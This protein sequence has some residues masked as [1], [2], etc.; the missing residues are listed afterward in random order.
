[1]NDF[2]LELTVEE[3]P[4]R[5]Q[6]T[7]IADF[8]RLMIAELE[9]LRIA[10]EDIRS[11]ISPKRIVFS[12]KLSEK[13]E[14]FVEEKKGPQIVAPT[15]VIEK[16]LKANNASKDDCV[17]REVDKKTFLFIEINHEARDVRDLLGEAIKNAVAKIPWKKSMRWGSGHFY[18][19]RPL[20]NIMAVFDGKPLEGEFEEI[21]LKFC[22]HTFGHRFL[23]P[24]KIEAKNV[25][26]YLENMRKAFVI[27]DANERRKM[28][29]NEFKKLESERNLSIEADEKLLDEVV[30]LIEH[31][32]V[33]LGKVPQKF[34]EL[35]EEA[36]IT[37]M[38]VHQR[39]F[40]TKSNGKL[41]PFFVF[42]ADNIA[43][44]GGKTIIAGNERVLNARLADALFFFETDL[45]KPLESRLEDLKKIAF[46][47]KL[48]TIFDRVQRVANVCDYLGDSLKFGNKESLRRAAILAKCDL[49][50]GMVGEFAE[51]QG[52]MGSHYARTQ[53]EP[54]EVCAAIRDQY[55]PVDE[56]S[57]KLSALLSLADKIELI[58]SFFAIGK[59]PTGSKDP[60]A[61]RRAAIGILKIIKNFNLDF[62]LKE[63]ICKAFDQLP[64]ENLRLDANNRVYAFILDR[65]KVLLKESGIRYDIANAVTNT[66]T[67]VIARSEAT[68]QSSEEDIGN[69]K[70]PHC[71]VGLRPPR[72]DDQM[73]AKR[74]NNIFIIFQN[75]SILNDFLQIDAGNKLLSVYKRVKNILEGANAAETFENRL[76]PS[77]RSRMTMERNHGVR[78]PSNEETKSSSANVDQSL[79]QE[80]EEIALFEKIEE[81]KHDFLKTRDYKERLLACSKI[82]ETASD[83]F[84]KVLVNA[85]DKQIKQN[86]LNL[87]EQLSFIFDQVIPNGLEG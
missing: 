21:G 50:S 33:L 18:F 34:M 41:A 12:A 17:Q 29:L 66:E 3:I 39:Y 79:F 11:F 54:P 28:I 44:D 55:R 56:I 67:A 81:L 71:R 61:L 35:P 62:D 38:R 51:L 85:D 82:H 27:A 77:L 53:G 52:I 80:K 30:G 42:V 63:I 22:G 8:E 72:N 2:L 31:P 40:P 75:A 43:T 76:D 23:A 6:S 10:Y 47:E 87:L 65:L 60:F 37:P 4:S 57:E 70:T 5:M 73:I 32:V 83:F 1:M 64:K 46:N 68:K 69:Q 26:E 84:D 9:G 19:V 25:D 59:E 45:Q 24:Q 36:I 74:K 58:T 20:R 16:F 7:A 14:E 15:E 49:S 78:S 48:G 13:T 86:R